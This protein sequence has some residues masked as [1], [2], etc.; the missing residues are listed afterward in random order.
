MGNVGP[1]CGR[2]LCQSSTS[3]M[4]NRLC[5][6][7]RDTTR[8][9]NIVDRQ[10]CPNTNSEICNHICNDVNFCRDEAYCN[11]FAY[12]R[13]C[14]LTGYYVSSSSRLFKGLSGGI[15]VINVAYM[16]IN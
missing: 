16:I 14:K 9:D 6:I 12:G 11:G 13:F 2:Y 10:V 3:E 5:S 1:L 8:C 7:N 4:T 15:K